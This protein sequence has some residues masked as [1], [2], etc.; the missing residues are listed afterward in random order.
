MT[1]VGLSGDVGG[2]LAVGLC[3]P[4]PNAVRR[5]VVFVLSLN[6]FAIWYKNDVF[7]VIFLL[8]KRKIFLFCAAMAPILEFVL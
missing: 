5:V 1:S 6:F 3:G 4:L 2:R 7:H 8:V